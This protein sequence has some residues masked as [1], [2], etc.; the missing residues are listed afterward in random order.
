[1]PEP[2]VDTKQFALD[3]I[4]YI[5]THAHINAMRIGDGAS[6]SAIPWYEAADEVGMLIYA[7][8]YGGVRCEGCQAK[9]ADK[10][11]P[12]GSAESAFE[13]YKKV[14]YGVAP[15]PSHVILILSNENDISGPHGHW[16]Y[17]PFA[18]QYAA[19]LRN[20]SSMLETWDPTRVV[21]ADA[22]F[23][24]GFGGQVMDDHSYFG[25]YRGDA[26][27]RQRSS[28]FTASPCDS[29]TALK[30]DPA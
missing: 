4:R 13:G 30:P 21:L 8:P 29:V 9:P 24:H 16:G 22:G 1:L 18:A 14:V 19:L 17:S 27:V 15:H 5:K 3:F 7:G 26:V 11:V 12:P 20:V 10:P 2:L 25:W 28:V 23:G 6:G